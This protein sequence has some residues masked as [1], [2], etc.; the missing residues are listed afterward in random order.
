MELI[1]LLLAGAGVAFVALVASL[2]LGAFQPRRATTGWALARG[3]SPTP[4]EAG[5]KFTE[6]RLSVTDGSVLPAWQVELKGN[7]GIVVL[8]HGFGRSRIDSLRRLMPFS[9]HLRRA[10]LLDLRGHGEA[11]GSRTH[12]GTDDHLDVIES[13][14]QLSVLDAPGE[15]LILAGHSMGAAVAL[16][17]ADELQRRGHRVDG[18]VLYAPYRRLREPLAGRLHTSGLPLPWLGA[19]AETCLG[20]ILPRTEPLETTAARLNQRVLVIAGA[21]DR[22]LHAEIARSIAAALPNAQLVVE[23][24][25]HGDVGAVRDGPAD[26]TIRLL[27]DSVRGST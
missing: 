24:A 22:M 3:L 25:V 13:L 15:P 20:F 19:L 21:D 2:V 6:H 4:A 5:W 7:S 11:D 18:L 10:I 26:T 17:A 9:H 8:L 1:L 27:L 12:L 16:R 14:R 23:P